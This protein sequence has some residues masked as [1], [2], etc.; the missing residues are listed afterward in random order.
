MLDRKQL[1]SRFEIIVLLDDTDLSEEQAAAMEQIRQE[2]VERADFE[3]YY[4]VQDY[5]TGS[6]K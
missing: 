3:L 2:V 6:N 5:F 1:E 4:S